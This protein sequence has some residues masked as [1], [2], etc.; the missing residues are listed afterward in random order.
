MTN[1]GSV[2]VVTSSIEG[3]LRVYAEAGTQKFVKHG[4]HSLSR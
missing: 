1:T 3:E 2:T 4:Q